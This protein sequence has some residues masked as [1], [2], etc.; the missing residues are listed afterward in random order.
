M[1]ISECQNKKRLS[2][3]LIS[4]VILVAGCGKEDPKEHLQKGVEYF[5]SGDYEK[6]VLELKT[7]GQGD[8]NVA[9]TYY[10]L[11]MLDE[12]NRQYKAM[13]ENLKKTLELQPS[14]SEARLKL[15]KVQLLLGET[16][17]ATQQ[18]E[19][20]LKDKSDDADAL[21]LKASVLMRK[22]NQNDAKIII[23]SI[24]KTNPNHVDALLLNAIIYMEKEK[25]DD[26]FASVNAA[27][28][29]D[30]NNV[31]LRMFKIQLNAKN[32][33][34]D[35]IIADYNELITLNPDNQE[36]KITLAKIYAQSGKKKEAEDLLNSLIAA[37]PDDVTLKLLLLDFLTASQPE[38]V[39]EKANQFTEQYKKQPKTLFSFASWM[40]AKNDLEEAKKVLNQIIALDDDK[41]D[42]I[43]AKIQLAKIAFSQK[44]FETS[45]KIADE[46]LNKNSNYI[47]AKILQARLLLAKSQYDE[48]IE[49][50]TKILWDKADSE[51]ALILLG[52][53]FAIKGDQKQA[54]KQ[55]LS[56]LETHP[57]NLQ[58]LVYLYENA[59]TNQDVNYAQQLIEKALRIEPENLVLL[60]KLVKL[61]ISM[62]KW[63]DA[64]LTVQRIST[65]SNPQAQNLAS[66]LEGQ[67]FQ[68]QGEYAKAITSYK[69]LMTNIS[70]NYDVLANMA[71]CYE[72]LNKKPEMMN[73]LNEILSKNPQNVSVGLVLSNLWISEKQFE[74]SNTLLT[75]LISAN[76][77]I[78]ELYIALAK[79]KLKQGDAKSAILIYK[80]GL[81]QNSTDVKLLFPL[82]TVYETQGD[83]DAAV[84]TYETLLEN[85]P[86]L[87]LAVNNLASILSEHYTS[88]EKLKKAVQLAQKFKDAKQPYYKD[89]YAWAVVKQGN[90]VEGLNLLNQIIITAPNVPIFRYHLGVVHYKNGNNGAALAEL[91]QALELS[92][93]YGN[94]SE[95]KATKL[96][97]DE[98]QAKSKRSRIL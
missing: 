92:A 29:L 97:L 77:K 70:D 31:S 50:L 83:Y 28:K 25:L 48:A 9:D 69:K 96:L 24:L 58:A 94:F 65:N 81:K 15:G 2:I 64:K 19:T 60:E 53:T 27:I 7:S 35:A 4:S 17:E 6:A 39:Q 95:E 67:I 40:I 98:I 76:P 82:A 57:T 85:N 38:K 62:T 20:L 59:L 12:K 43:S 86:N 13:A 33:N 5:K 3:A 18:A 44:D 41:N 37:K 22:N 42:V 56:V 49:L 47:D 52:Q 80:D 30:K 90:L 73:L 21:L 55:F 36:F 8:K 88:D 87:D 84:S 34:I 23:D 91:K 66:Y 89:T 74:K 78:S 71:K 61:N 26:A 75:N 54:E 63:N 51:D 72:A 46:I 1:F 45:K 68:A 14:H 10:Y 32:K 16:D 93:K 79:V 11:A